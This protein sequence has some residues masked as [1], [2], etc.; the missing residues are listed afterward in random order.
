MSEEVFTLKWKYFIPNL[1]SG[2]SDVFKENS[3]SDVTL[4]SDD[5]IPL[6]AHK[7]VL[8][9]ASPVLKDILLNNPHSH[10]LIY[11]R[12]VKH[13]DLDAI[14][15][16]IYFGEAAFSH[17][18]I[19]SFIETATDLQLKQNWETAGSSIITKAE[20]IN[21]PSI[22]SSME[23]NSFMAIHAIMEDDSQYDHIVSSASDEMIN[24]DIPASKSDSDEQV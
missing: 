2:L 22:A 16:L 15:Q 19:D 6:Q 10:P 8:S 9:A 17:G 5:K 14:L 23:E 20:P 21:A 3:F 18:N 1:S 24:L 11:L 4:V 12:G 7:Y 13:Q